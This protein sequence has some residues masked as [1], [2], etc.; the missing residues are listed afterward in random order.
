MPALQRRLPQIP[1][2]TLQPACSKCSA[3]MELAHTTPFKVHD[4]IDRTY[5]CPK[6]GHSEAWVV[7]EL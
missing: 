6:C 1:G 4:E 3:P 7:N 5:K 2:L